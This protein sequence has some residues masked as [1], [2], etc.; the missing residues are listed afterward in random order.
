MKGVNYCRKTLSKKSTS[1]SKV[2]FLCALQN[3]VKI[4]LDE[5][6]FNTHIYFVELFLFILVCP[7]FAICT[8]KSV[9]VSRGRL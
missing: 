6:F 1:C 9:Y 3:P 2:Q 5:T 8:L 7:L 4:S